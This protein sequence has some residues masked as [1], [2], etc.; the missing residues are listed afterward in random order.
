MVTIVTI[1]TFIVDLCIP[2]IFFNLLHWPLS[3][4]VA[5]AKPLHLS[6]STEISSFA[7]PFLCLHLLYFTAVD[8]VFPQTAC[9]L[10]H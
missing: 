7:V 2:Y 3:P 6:R 4:F 8:E 9:Q 10:N 1:L 5:P